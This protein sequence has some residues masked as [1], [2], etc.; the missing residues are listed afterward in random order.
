L[1][2]FSQLSAKRLQDC[3]QEVQHLCKEVIRSKD[4]TIICG[5]RN[6]EEQ[7][8][9]FRLR[10]STKQ[11][12]DSKHNTFPSPAVD[13]APYPVDWNDKA[14]FARLFGY[15]ERVAEELGYRVVWGADWDM[16]GFTTDHQLVDMP[17]V[18][19]YKKETT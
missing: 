1:P 13:V 19:V 14:R 10:R 7:N 2:K 5:F 6:K 3:T 4:F 12:P 9:A 8:E 11:W 18:E 16:D 15:M 17:H